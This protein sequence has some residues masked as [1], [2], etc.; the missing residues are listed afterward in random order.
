MVEPEANLL[1][2]VSSY[3]LCDHVDRAHVTVGILFRD[4]GGSARRSSFAEQ[5]NGDASGGLAHHDILSPH[6]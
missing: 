5:Q 1:F 4:I 2:T 6:S 3:F